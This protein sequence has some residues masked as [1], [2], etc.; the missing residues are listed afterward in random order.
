MKNTPRERIT[1]TLLG[2]LIGVVATGGVYAKTQV[3]VEKN[4]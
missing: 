2:L 3:T 1:M 4:P